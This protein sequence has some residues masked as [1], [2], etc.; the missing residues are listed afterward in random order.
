MP[1][2][3]ALWELA[4]WRRTGTRPPDAATRAGAL[5]AG[6]LVLAAWYGYVHAQLG[7]WPATYEDGNLGAPLVG[8]AEAFDRA[9]VLASG[10]F[11]QSQIGVTA[12]PLL[13]AIAVILIAAAV[14]AVRL[15]TPLDGVVLGMVAIAASMG[16]RTLLYPHELVRNPAVVL[17][18]AISSLLIASP[19]RD[20]GGTTAQGPTPP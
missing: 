19:P 12:T 14:K 15:R 7:A 5:A 10:T 11:E 6:P 1:I 13:I 2:G 4:V 9:T 18:V 16:W 8:W 17:L 20:R 3:L